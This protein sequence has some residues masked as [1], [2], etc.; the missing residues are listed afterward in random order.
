MRTNTLEWRVAVAD[1]LS[2]Q[3]AQAEAH[4]AWVVDEIQALALEQQA[5]AFEDATGYGSREFDALLRDIEDDLDDW[6]AAAEELWISVSGMGVDDAAYAYDMDVQATIFRA[7]T[8]RD[9]ELDE[10][11]ARAQASIRAAK[12]QR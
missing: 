9:R 1:R 3:E 12:P 8:A 10:E 5:L 11:V 4:L 2:E 6:C 7:L